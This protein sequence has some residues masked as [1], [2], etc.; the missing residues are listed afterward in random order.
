MTLYGLRGITIHTIGVGDPE[1]PRNAWLVG[2][3]GPKEALREEQVAFD[4][5]LRAEGLS[6]WGT[7]VLNTLF[8]LA[9]MGALMLRNRRRRNRV[10]RATTPPP[11][12]GAFPVPPLPREV[13]HA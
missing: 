2:P 9:V 3:P 6:P 4:V 1:P 11:D 5:T 7:V 12:A 13:T 10:R 8:T